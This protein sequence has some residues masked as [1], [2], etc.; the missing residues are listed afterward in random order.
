MG[1]SSVIRVVYDLQMAR[2]YETHL[3]VPVAPQHVWDQVHAVLR[4]GLGIHT[5]GSDYGVIHAATDMSWRTWGE[6]ITVSF[7]PVPEGTKV[8][9]RSQCAFPLQLVDMG[10]N[11]AN[12]ETIA[13]GIQVPGAAP[14]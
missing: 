7:T 1:S 2:K 12:V 8:A 5:I 11:K 9:I 14:K 10:K 4:A 13:A 3:T 6:R